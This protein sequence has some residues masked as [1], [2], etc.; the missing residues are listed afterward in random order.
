MVFG[1]FTYEAVAHGAGRVA[2]VGGKTFR[3]WAEKGIDKFM[4]RDIWDFNVLNE[5]IPIED[6]LAMHGIYPERGKYRLRDDD[7]H[8]SASINKG[9]IGNKIHDFGMGNTFTPLTLTMFLNGVDAKDAAQILGEAFHI[10]PKISSKDGEI[11]KG[12]IF[13]F[14]WKTL[15]L[16]SDMV[17]KN[18]DLDLERYD[19]DKTKELA[20]RY[21]MSMSELH[22]QT[23]G[24]KDPAKVDMVDKRRYENIMRNKAVPYAFEKRDEYFRRMHDD[25]QLAKLV[26][27]GMEIDKIF[28]IH[29]DEYE[30]MAME[31]AKIEN[32]LRRALEGTTVKF[33]FRN[34]CP[35]DDFR[36]VINGEVPFEIGFT[37]QYEVGA[38]AYRQKA[39]VFYT[40]FSLDE[41][42]RLMDNGLEDLQVA[43]RQKG[44]QV[45]ISFVST[46]AS[47]VNYLV[48][49]LRGKEAV[50]AT[51]MGEALVNAQGDTKDGTKMREA[52]RGKQSYE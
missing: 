24:Q 13:D 9:R 43:A 44:E 35:M 2:W 8:A 22:A 15:G 28:K 36:K 29:K 33:L 4:G 39:K 42:H 17:S 34:Y 25:Y 5:V 47:K 20:E 41:Y 49:A 51:T 10:P 30:N 31:L 40:V 21:R 23:I 18:I 46:D 3:Q 52:Q 32:V 14:E 16:Y 7:D 48:K 12:K 1:V 27:S 50:L 38:S 19:W 37:T 6:V 11:N 26:N 45:T